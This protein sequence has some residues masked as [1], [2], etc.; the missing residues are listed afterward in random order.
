MKEYAVAVVSKVYA[1]NEMHAREIAKEKLIEIAKQGKI[2]IRDA[3]EIKADF[4]RLEE[5]RRKLK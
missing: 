1:S 2:I 3:E 4:E 5:I